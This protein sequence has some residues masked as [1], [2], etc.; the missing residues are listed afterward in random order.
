MY[1][2]RGVTGMSSLQSTIE[3]IKNLETEKKSLLQE[4]DELKRMAD[5]KAAA[6][7]SEVASLRE[8][9]KTLKTLM[10]QEQPTVSQLNENQ[11]KVS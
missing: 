10:G 7:E 6:L 9:A 3:K 4:I 8:E 2:R 5:A 1:Y 11:L